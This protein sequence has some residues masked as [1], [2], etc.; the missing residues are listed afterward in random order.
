MS[1]ERNQEIQF[2]K[3]YHILV[4]PT[5]PENISKIVNRLEKTHSWKTFHDQ[6][7]CGEYEEIA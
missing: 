2:E 3:S 1:T 6:E 7:T 5:L 4:Y